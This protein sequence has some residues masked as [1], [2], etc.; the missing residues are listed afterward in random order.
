MVES[1]SITRGLEL[2]G[3]PVDLDLEDL[4]C[5]RGLGARHGHTCW[6]GFRGRHRGLLRGAAGTEA[7]LD[8][9]VDEA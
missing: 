7:L 1:D 3:F 9:D 2:D 8:C 4:G 5:G 6:G